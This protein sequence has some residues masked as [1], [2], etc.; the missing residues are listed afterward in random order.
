[1]RD[2]WLQTCQVRDVSCHVLCGAHR[3][4]SHVCCVECVAGCQ[5]QGSTSHQSWRRAKLGTL[6]CLSLNCLSG[7]QGNARYAGPPSQPSSQLPIYIHAY[8]HTYI[9]TYMCICMYIHVYICIYMY[10]YVYVYMYMYV[11]IYMYIYT[12]AFLGGD[13]GLIVDW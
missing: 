11:Y 9:H 8:I 1:V 7:D 2:M 4:C 10:I 6:N 12:V 5:G 3:W 13:H